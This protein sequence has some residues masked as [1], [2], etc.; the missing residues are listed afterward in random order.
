M[1][2]YTELTPPTAVTHSLSVP[3]LSRSANNLIVAKTSLLQ[4]FALKSLITHAV[5]G[6]ARDALRTEGLHGRPSSIS[7]PS[8]LQRGER[9]QSTKLVLIAQY[10]LSGT[11]TALARVKILRSRSG[12]EAILIALRD[13]KLSLVE[14][15]PERYSISTISIHY[16]EQEDV[17]RSPWESSLSRSPTYLSVDPSSRCAALKF[18]SRQLAILP[19]YQE[20]DDLVMDDYDPEIDGERP[21]VKT[22]DGPLQI[23]KAPYAPSFVLSLLALDPTL[24]HPIHLSFLYEYREP[25][26]G[27]LFSQTSISNALLH[28]RR[29]NISYVVYTLDLEQQASTTLLSI[30]NL[31]C[32]L[33]LIVPLALPVGGA[34]LVG[35][36]MLIHVDQSG[37]TNGVAVNQLAKHSS[38]F[39]L[40]DQSDLALKLEDCVIENLAADNGDMLIILKTGELAILSFRSEGRS[41]SGLSVR[42]VRHPPGE[43]VLQAAASCTSIIGR[44]RIFAGS[45]NCDSIVLGWSR[46]SEKMKR[47]IQRRSSDDGNFRESS[48]LEED[49]FDEDDDDLYSGVKADSISK[50]IPRAPSITAEDED[51]VFRVHDYMTNLGPIKDFGLIE[52]GENHDDS[53]EESLIGGLMV[54]SGCGR[55]GS[56]GILQRKLEPHF[57][58]KLQIDGVTAVWSVCVK[59]NI[60]GRPVA[61]NGTRYD[62]YLIANTQTAAGSQSLLY[63]I[64]ATGL[65]QV[66]GTDFDPEAGPS[67]EIG[68]LTGGTRIVQVLPN[69]LRTFDNSKSPLSL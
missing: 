49:E 65:K 6:A 55:G 37:K 5:S 66:D 26:F 7:M 62:E 13:A 8:A 47:Q 15:D 41:V 11:V 1:Q 67:V 42:I 58:Q 10:E 33:F 36:N 31:P 2:S 35:S 17:K 21:T 12:G 9:L 43:E 56:L 51:Y 20:G 69:E 52:P 50:Q 28:E 60:G 48:D 16:Y 54:S 22:A 63:A 53:T 18:G 24:S 40:L 57:V 25:T 3:F 39:G 29:D 44:G 30:S 59:P 23:D 64:S 27:V 34:L 45:E 14:W 61:D 38:S 46:R 32:D 4:I 19:F 68:V